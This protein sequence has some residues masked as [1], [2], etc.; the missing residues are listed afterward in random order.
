MSTQ[1]QPAASA[2]RIF[3]ESFLG[4]IHVYADLPEPPE[5]RIVETIWADPDQETLDNQA[6]LKELLERGEIR[7]LP[8]TPNWTLTNG[9]CWQCCRRITS[10][11]YELIQ[12]KDLCE[13]YGIVQAIVDV[14]DYSLSDW[15][16]FIQQ[17]G[18]ESLRDF[19]SN[20]GNAL[21][22]DVLAKY[23]FCT[24][25]EEYLMDDFYSSLE[26]AVEHI[27]RIVDCPLPD[28][29]KGKAV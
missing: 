19:I 24:L 26:E 17:F 1:N 9:A 8:Q 15:E 29:E 13:E 23:I 4:Q 14:D 5:L 21:R 12:L 6:Y 2:A 18:H 28:I 10:R 7:E 20:S 22:L 25:W 27:A 11:K 3:V 16:Y